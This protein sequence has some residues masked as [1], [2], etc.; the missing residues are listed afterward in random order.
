MVPATP[1]DVPD[2]ISLRDELAG[3]LIG[4]GIQ[5]W[6]PGDFPEEHLGKWV[7]DG[8][9]RTLREDGRLVA[10]IAVLNED[11][12]WS[13]DGVS[14]G[15]VHVLMVARS[16]AGRGLGSAVLAAAEQTI[17]ENGR[18]W[19]RLDAV[20]MNHRLIR[21]YLHQGY[22]RAGTATFDTSGTRPTALLHKPLTAR[23]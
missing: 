14:A 21:W 6:E 23:T 17:H 5:Q 3:W 12:I 18:D 9:V 22:T 15:Y 11:P 7:G 13:P 1:A 19:V 10:T 4:R 2:L 16:H 20:A 8:G